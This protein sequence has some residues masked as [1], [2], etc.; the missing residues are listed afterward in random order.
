MKD[1]CLDINYS[2]TDVDIFSE[3]RFS[4]LDDDNLYS[5]TN[6]GQYSLFRNDA[7]QRNPC[8]IRPFGGTALYSH[9]DYYPGYP[10]CA[11]RNGVEITI[12]QCMVTPHI[13]IV[14]SYRSP[15]VSVEQLC[16]VLKHTLESLQTQVNLF[17]GDFNVNYFKKAQCSSLSN[18]RIRDNGYW[19][20]VSCSTTDSNTSIDHINTNLPKSQATL[21]VLETYFSHHKAVCALL[22][23]Y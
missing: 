22:N 18:L 3:T 9:L 13:T 1:V 6:D 20:L 17:I 4:H 5:L 10:Y 12:L 11:N 23:C 2:T 15:A 16:A 21:Q 7:Q 8:N 14:G 19:Q